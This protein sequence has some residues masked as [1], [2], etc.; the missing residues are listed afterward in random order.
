MRLMHRLDRHKM[1]NFEENFAFQGRF[2]RK[3]STDFR[4]WL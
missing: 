1:E 3:Q 2:S 4:E